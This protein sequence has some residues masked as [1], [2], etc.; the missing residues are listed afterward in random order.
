MAKKCHVCAKPA[1]KPIQVPVCGDSQAKITVCSKRCRDEYLAG[2]VE[3]HQGKSLR[4]LHRPHGPGVVLAILWASYGLVHMVG[5][6]LLRFVPLPLLPARPGPEFYTG[7]L[8]ALIVAFAVLRNVRNARMFSTGLAALGLVFA[9]LSYLSTG[10]TA[11]LLE[12]ATV[13]PAA[14]LLSLGDPGPKRALGGLGL[15]AFYPVALVVTAFTGAYSV[16]RAEEQAA[17]ESYAGP[18]HEVP[19]AGLRF[20]VPGGWYILREESML[21]PHDGALFRALRPDSR[22]SVHVYDRQDCRPTDPVRMVHVLDAFTA[23]GARPELEQGLAM[24]PVSSPFGEGR[25]FFVRMDE[26]RRQLWYIVFLPWTEGRCLEL[27]CGGAGE[28]AA[29]IRSECIPLGVR[30]LSALTGP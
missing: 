22:L 24:L 10:Q 25:S 2:Y 7:G 15:F 28:A 5:P 17:S 13:H 8:A 18:V 11:Y 9:G 6:V 1:R 3:T 26:P 27:R 14:L 21:L 12:A 30:S 4:L 20:T 16:S 23:A 29:A 19:S